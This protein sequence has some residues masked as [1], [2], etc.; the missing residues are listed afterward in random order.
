LINLK[1]ILKKEKYLGVGELA[2][3]KKKERKM[4]FNN[5]IVV[6]I[7]IVILLFFRKYLTYQYV[8]EDVS[9]WGTFYTVFGVLYAV[10]TGF[11]IIE[12]LSKYNKIQ[13]IIQEEI[14]TLQDMRDLVSF[15]HPEP[16]IKSSILT[17]LKEYA[18]S[19]A[20][21]EL[22]DNGKSE[23][24]KLNK[25]SDTTKQ[26]Y[27]IFKQ[28]NRIEIKEERD[29]IFV[30]M[31]IQKMMDVTTFRTKRIAVSAQ[32]LPYSL[33]LLLKFMS[34]ALIAGIVLLGVHSTAIH[35]VMIVSLVF[36]LEL[37]KSIILD[38]DN[39]YKGL[40]NIKS[41]PFKN[42]KENLLQKLQEEND[43]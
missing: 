11:L 25:N 26:M 38:I 17:E 2:S 43:A 32:K 15:L 7:S 29:R 16:V 18:Q 27:D 40:W 13:D 41:A 34:W 20:E 9:A 24:A 22:K 19:V 39:P 5:L 42:F 31:L 33:K 1:K 35:I 28:I 8:F 21:H 23:N 10:I 4:M 36:S 30:N 14:N 37:L 12:A 3:A 6:L